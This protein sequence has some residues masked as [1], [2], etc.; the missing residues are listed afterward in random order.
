M[1]FYHVH[2]WTVTSTYEIVMIIIIIIALQYTQT[3]FI[4]RLDV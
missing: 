4:A 2:C 1:Q 3:R